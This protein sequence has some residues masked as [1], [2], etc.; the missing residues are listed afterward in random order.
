MFQSFW[1]RLLSCIWPKVSESD[2]LQC[3]NRFVLHRTPGLPKWTWVFVS[4][5]LSLAATRKDAP[6]NQQIR[7]SEA[8]DQNNPGLTRPKNRVLLLHTQPDIDSGS[9]LSRPKVQNLLL[10]NPPPSSRIKHFK[11]FILMLQTQYLMSVVF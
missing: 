8:A 11:W 6:F 5:G 9:W 2:L 3:W 7:R 1:S 10:I 4:A